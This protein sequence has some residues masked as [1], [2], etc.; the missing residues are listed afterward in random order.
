MISE[1]HPLPETGEIVETLG[2]C[3]EVVDTDVR[4]IDKVLATRL[5]YGR[6]CC[7]DRWPNGWR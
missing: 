3:F 2:W 1:L 7:T 5:G 6:V 4:R